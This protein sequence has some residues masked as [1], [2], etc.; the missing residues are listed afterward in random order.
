VIAALFEHRSGRIIAVSRVIFAIIFFGAV[1]VDPSTPAEPSNPVFQIL[2]AYLM[3]AIV[4]FAVAMRSWWW[5]HLLAWPMLTVDILALLAAVFLTEGSS[6]DFTSPFL[7]IFAF[8][9]LSATIRW[10]WRVTLGAA[11]AVTFLYCA[12]GLWVSVADP[13]FNTVRFGRRVAYLLVLSLI[14]VWFGLQRREQHID[15]FHE[16]PQPVPAPLPPLEEALAF[17]IAQSGA[18]AGAIA[19]NDTEEP[20]TELRTQGLSASRQQL[21]PETMLGD[22]GVGQRARI[23]SADR[24]RSLRASRRGRPVALSTPATEPLADLLGVGEALA[25][26]V[27]GGTGSGEIVLSGISGICEDHVAI[28]ALIGRELEAAL[29]RHAR[30]MLLHESGLARSREA[31]ARDLHDSVAQS[32]AGAAMRVEGLR[33]S[34]QAGNDPEVEIGQIKE[35]LRAEQRHVR[36]MIDRLRYSEET[37]RSVDLSASMRRVLEELSVRWAISIGG[38]AAE[39]IMVPI[40]LDYEIA[41]LLREAV[42]NAVRHGKATEVGVSIDAGEGGIVIEIVDNGG[43]FAAG[44][45]P[46]APRSIRERTR[47]HGGDLSVRSGPD[48]THLAIDLP[49]EI[50]A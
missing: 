46:E 10:N 45:G 39:P 26:P 27:T 35:A 31:L 44:T 24:R 7:A 19:W 43:G 3:L 8:V 9:M 20:T 4:L 6:N 30:L 49:L 48:G 34:I 47:R 29:D 13:D 28:G 12:L 17:A 21:G 2:G 5:D 40:S 22:A 18:R 16:Q 14:L 36:T 32:L 41:N 33:R 15:R 25:F 38:P 42:A 37:E 50:A 23:F 11:V 1:L